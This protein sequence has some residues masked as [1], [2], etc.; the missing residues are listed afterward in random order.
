M[1][2]GAHKLLESAVQ[3]TLHAHA[4]SRSSSQASSV[5]TDLLSRYLALLTSTCA[6]YSQHAGRTG[7]TVRDAIGA[8]D[9]L[10]VSME[11]LSEY[12]ATEGKEL[13]RYALYSARRVEDLHEFKSQLVDGLRQDRDDAIPLEYA[14][15][16]PKLLE[17]EEE[18]DDEESE[19]DEEEQEVNNARKPDILTAGSDMDVDSSPARTEA[20]RKRPPSR[21]TTPTLP[22]SPISNPSS[23]PQRK[24]ARTANWEPPEYIPDFLP[25]FPTTSE[26]AP[27]SPL[28]LGPAAHDQP[29][30][31]PPTAQIP[32][33]KLEKQPVTLSQSLTSAA[34]SDILVQVP[35]SQ[36]SLASVP[37]WHLPSAA[38]PP[39]NATH[40]R[41]N[42]LPTPLVEPSLISAY[43]HILTHPPP[44]ELP[45]LNPS[46][47]KVAMALMKQAQSNRRWNP[48]DT[49][50]GSVAPCSP[51]VAS[52]GPTYPIAVNDLIG[53]EVKP[54]ADGP[55]TKLPVTIYR[56]VAGSDPMA[57]LISQQT[58]RIP[59]LARNVLPSTILTRTS[60]LS[61]PP[62]LHRGNKPLI[63]GNGIAAP[64]NA[65][66]V[67]PGPDGAPGTTPSTSKSKETPSTNAKE[68]PVKPVFPDAR[69][70]ATW[71]YDTKDFRIPLH[72]SARV[73][74]RVGSIQAGG[75]GLISLPLSARSKGAK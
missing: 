17:E 70:F 75:S 36:S 13:N 58:S 52:I 7:L 72:P 64:W 71:D 15:C 41:Q 24:R 57:P 8:L 10:G 34:A 26:D 30:I 60:R 61:H 22:L 49:L 11:E 51:R 47:H 28:A 65:N 45:P 16:P 12:C 67:P 14:Y 2:S 6:K 50:F 73:R 4:F 62:V 25:P 9:E 27:P 29:V 69:L 18:D 38:P 59:E 48:A 31:P 39:P 32:E 56:P 44:P 46:R 68:S 63:Y 21:P 53:N 1:E 43:H 55:E 33:V 20:L 42:R 37:E 35:Y 19:E 74:N 54:K 3:R 40:T 66:A 23:S 5:L